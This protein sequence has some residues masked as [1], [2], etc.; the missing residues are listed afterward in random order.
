MKT[1]QAFSGPEARQMAQGRPYIAVLLAL[2]AAWPFTLLAT[3]ASAGELTCGTL[4]AEGCEAWTTFFSDGDGGSPLV[5]A[6]PDGSKVILAAGNRIPGEFRII[7]NAYDP[8]T[9]VLLWNTSYM[10]RTS[11]IVDG[12]GIS[13]DS[14]QV[15]I[16]GTHGPEWP[17]RA[18][19]F[20]YDAGN[21]AALW[22]YHW[23]P[24][25]AALAAAGSPD[26]TRVFVVGWKWD[27]YLVAS[28]DTTTGQKLWEASYDNHGGQAPDFHSPS[29]DTAHEV[30]VSLDGQ[31]VF[32]TG[33]SAGADGTF[34]YATLAYDAAT[35]AQRWVA[36][37][38]KAMLANPGGLLD[39]PHTGSYDLA[40]SPDGERVFVMG[41]DG[42]FAYDIQTGADLWGHGTMGA[43][44]RQFF[45]QFVD[46]ECDLEVSPDGSRL[47]AGTHNNIAAY[48]AS[49]GDL[50]WRLPMAVADD[51]AESS[52][53]L[54]NGIEMSPDGSRIYA[55][56]TGTRDPRVTNFGG[57][58]SAN[59]ETIGLDATHG[60]LLWRV[61]YDR[62][63][64]SEPALAMSPDGRRVFVAGESTIRLPTE[65]ALLAYDTDLGLEN[66]PKFP[67]FTS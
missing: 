47:F 5:A 67:S 38:E 40:L 61:V 57:S 9:G 34:G 62:A 16:T 36:R 37:H 12:L 54:G 22:S 25:T 18:Y 8:Q 2:L 45:S 23:E 52:G 51:D 28:F 1:P 21:G 53:Y 14:K 15:Y 64:D 19:I 42:A 30:L 41:S 46:G 32:V 10:P 59:Y 60:T 39:P 20:T 4:I 44:C 6:T 27:N 7:V 63:W 3:P 26:G 50:V 66:A 65:L 35:G 43:A 55:V 13:L 58:E 29:F 33:L 31:T 49:N 48:D 24:G 56:S 11:P 17:P